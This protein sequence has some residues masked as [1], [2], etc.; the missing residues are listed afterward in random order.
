MTCSPYLNRPL[1]S[2]GQAWYDSYAR[3][4]PT[5]TDG[6][7]RKAWDSLL[8]CSQRFYERWLQSCYF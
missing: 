8:P 2:L 4:N 1:R 7:P 5:H 3:R 6:T